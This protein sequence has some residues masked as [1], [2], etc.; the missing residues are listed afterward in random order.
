MTA[1]RTRSKNAPPLVMLTAYDYPSAQAA[2]AGG[3]DMVLVGD[4]AATNVLG[5][6]STR[7]ISVDELLMLTRA[8]RRGVRTALLVGDLPFSTYEASDDLAVA[9]ARRFADVGC[10]LVKVEGAA[11]IAARVRAIVA[12]GIA[13]VGH[14]GL[15]PQGAVNAEDL[16]VRGRSADEAAA[17]VSDARALEAAGAS[18]LV[19]EAVPA[20]VADEVARHVRIPVIGIGAGAG[21]DGQVLVYHDLLGL[22]TGHVAKFVRPYAAQHED[23]VRAITAYAADVRARRFPADAE[24]YAMSDAELAAFRARAAR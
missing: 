17:I 11:E 12:C 23:A 19:V 2:D 22:G 3:V 9:T 1:L 4:S 16:K 7:E 21:V 20:P 14:V 13:V 6:R 10:D 15:L 8:A 5:Y 18:A 24:T